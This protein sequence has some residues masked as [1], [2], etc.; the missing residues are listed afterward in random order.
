MQAKRRYHFSPSSSSFPPNEYKS[1]LLS[2]IYLYNGNSIIARLL[3]PFTQSRHLRLHS[4]QINEPFPCLSQHRQRKWCTRRF[5]LWLDVPKSSGDGAVRLK[6]EG[7]IRE[8]RGDKR[9]LLLWCIRAFR[10]RDV[11]LKVRS[12]YQRRCIS[13]EYA[14]LRGSNFVGINWTEGVTPQLAKPWHSCST[15]QKGRF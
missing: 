8:D 15:P 6:D 10:R 5:I 7:R 11:L 4:A 12:A 13:V 3:P 1:R 9:L 14:D 2:E